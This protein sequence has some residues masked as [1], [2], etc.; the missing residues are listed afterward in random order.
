MSIQQT[1]TTSFKQDQLLG[2]QNL[3][4]D[5]L[6]LALYTS[7]ASLGPSTTAYTTAE[8]VTGSGYTAG[9][10]ILTGVTIST[11]TDGVVYVNFANAVWSPAAF[12]ARGGLI[13]NSSKA[14]KSIA[15]LNFGADKTC[16]TQFVVQFP[17]NTSTSAIL[18]FA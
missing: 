16:T 4:T 3:Q 13:Y 2:A 14:N 15:V 12:T 10:Q 7:G 1:L 6:K 18:R 5:T 17:A 8:E 11:A 9:G